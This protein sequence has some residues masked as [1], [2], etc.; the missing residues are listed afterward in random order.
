MRT[1][2]RRT[3]RMKV[4]GLAY[5]NLDPDN[6]G[7][8]LDISEGGL[9]FQSTAPIKRT[10]VIRFWFSYRGLRVEHGQ[11]GTEGELQ[12]RGVSRLVEVRSELTWSDETMRR[13]GLRFTNL[14]ETAREQIRDWIRQ[15]ALVH[16][17]GGAPGLFPSVRQSSTLVAR[18]ASARFEAIFRRVQSSRLWNRFTGGVATGIVVTAF[19]VGTFSSF[20]HNHI[21]GDSLVAMG[22]RLGGK[23]L[24]PPDSGV[25]QPNYIAP[26][27]AA[28]V[29]ESLSPTER[30]TAQ[31]VSDP[32]LEPE[33]FVSNQLQSK[34][35]LSSASLPP[36]TKSPATKPD[37]L[38]PS[39]PSLASPR[40]PVSVS[41]ASTVVPEKAVFPGIGFTSAPDLGASSVRPPRPDVAIDN[42]PVV[43]IESPNLAGATLQ[44][45][46]F[47]EVGKFKARPLADETTRRL[48]QLGF[49]TTVI[50]RSRLFMKSYQVLVGP[51]G[52]D[53]QAEAVH[54][55]LSSRGFSPRSYE[56]G[57]RNFYMPA[58]LEVGAKRV[59]AG[60]CVISWESYSP[61]A[62]VKI[63]NNKDPDVSVQGKWLK[64]GTKY[65]QDAVGYR[66]NGDGSRTLI[67]IRFSGMTQT[68]VF[69]G[70]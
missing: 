9:C 34:E 42:G 15:P 19:L 60:P 22:E 50:P 62:I 30:R 26:E 35:K 46:K 28:I 29:P 8:I 54:K 3:P 48:S 68:L 27:I 56:R 41:P 4:N 43:H 61:D 2:R 23:S 55:D 21:L 37:A 66:K 58:S 5:V 7:V 24:P 57:K 25:P 44:S 10:E 70:N 6:G 33:V 12:L 39:S 47:L 49:P 63:D 20:T 69:G 52:T 53:P 64:Q 32:D 31:A 45:E 16:V 17:N 67:E 18:V 11:G 14:S 13:G 40:I 1:E 51:Y 38:P 59:P 36:G 65:G